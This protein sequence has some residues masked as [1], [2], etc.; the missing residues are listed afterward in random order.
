MAPLAAWSP[1]AG[2]TAA[3]PAYDVRF[4]VKADGETQT[5][6]GTTTFVI[7]ADGKVTGT[8]KVTQPTIVDAALAGAVKGDTWTFEY[9][10]AIPEQACQGIVTGTGK[11]SAD[12]KTI[13]GQ[14]RIAGECAP[15]P[16]E[17]S[18][19]FVRK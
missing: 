12:R 6:L 4:D 16:L 7:A 3:A 18:F 10:Y 11:V 17:A 5:Y 14:A 8:M 19:S 13:E 2:Q 9:G 15:T 1:A